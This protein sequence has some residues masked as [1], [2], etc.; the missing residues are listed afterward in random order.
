LGVS[1]FVFRRLGWSRFTC[2]GGSVVGCGGRELEVPKHTGSL[3]AISSA[4][5][6]LD[7]VNTTLD[8]S[9]NHHTLCL[10]FA[11]LKSMSQ[12]DCQPLDDH[13]PL[14]LVHKSTFQP[15]SSLKLRKYIKKKKSKPAK[16]NQEVVG[17]QVGR[18]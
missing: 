14:A 15:F 7:E 1:R 10:Q 2:G 8:G 11:K 4:Y 6:I 16:E 13:K 12:P 17:K 18:V 9:I 5:T 3:E